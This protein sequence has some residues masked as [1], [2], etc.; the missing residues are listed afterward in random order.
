MLFTFIL[1]MVVFKGGQIQGH[2]E[3]MKEQRKIYK[4]AYGDSSKH[5]FWIERRCVNVYGEDE[6]ADFLWKLRE[7]ATRFK[8]LEE[9]T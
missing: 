6:N 3:G 2:Q 5:L 9:T 4:S 1:L 8:A 7:I